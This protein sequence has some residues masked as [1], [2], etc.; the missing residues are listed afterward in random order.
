V[1]AQLHHAR[2][3]LFEPVFAMNPPLLSDNSSNVSGAA[4]GIERRFETWEDLQKV[5]LPKWW[6]EV[7][8]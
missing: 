2:K 7:T 5:V 6:I 8:H 4:T 1:R 3:L